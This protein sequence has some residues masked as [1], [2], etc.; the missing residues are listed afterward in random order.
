M[1]VPVVLGQGPFLEFVSGFL[2]ANPQIRIDLFI[3]NQ[4]VDLI[5]ENVD[6]AIRF[7]ELQDSTV[8][9]TRLGKSVRYV[10]AA[11]GVSEGPQA[12]RPSLPISRNTLAP[13]S[14]RKTMPR[15]GI[16]SAA[17][18]KREFTCRGR[19]RAATSIP[20]AHSSIAG[21]ASDFCRRTTATVKSRRGGWFDCCRSG[22]RRPSRCSRFIRAASSC[23]SDWC[24]PA[25][26]NDVAK[27]G[28]AQGMSDAITWGGSASATHRRSRCD[29]CRRLVNQPVDSLPGA[30][31]PS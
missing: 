1:S 12:S 13:C 7:G 29:R 19:S 17:E 25:G 15:T 8:V 16:W 5:A 14:A 21:T 4:F 30:H 26:G 3:T 20:S 23:R 6:V 10:V 31:R 24:I 28:V 27:P 9:A 22:R 11:P 2:K 18:R